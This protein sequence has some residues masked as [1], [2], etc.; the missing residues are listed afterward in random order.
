MSIISTYPKAS[1]DNKFLQLGLS[2]AVIV[3]V[4]PASSS[5]MMQDS[6]ALD[7]TENVAKQKIIHEPVHRVASKPNVASTPKLELVPNVPVPMKAN[8]ENVKPP[9]T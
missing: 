6:S 8:R 9:A 2:V 7:V 5:A 1:G 3:S 4:F